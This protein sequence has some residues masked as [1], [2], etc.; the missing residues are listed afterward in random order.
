MARNPKLEHIKAKVRTRGDVREVGISYFSRLYPI[1]FHM[2]EVLRLHA[3]NDTSIRTS[4]RQYVIALAGHL[5]TFFRDIFRFALEQDVSFFDRIVQE[6]RLRVPEESVLAQEGVTRYDFVS[7]AMTLQSVGSI[8][9]AFDLLFLP[10]GFRTSIETTRLAYAIPSRAA[11]VHGFPLSA[12]PNWWQDLTQLFELR[13][14]LTH[15]ANSTTCIEPSHIAR[16][17]SLAVILPQYMTLMVFTSGGTEANKADA[18]PA[19]FLIEDFL[20]TDWKIVL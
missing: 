13:H 4:I 9:G 15:D 3:G 7:E 12:F 6:H 14:E 11:L 20:A 10:D 5:E 8:A 18:I 17:E 2:H 1:V 19:I 16:L